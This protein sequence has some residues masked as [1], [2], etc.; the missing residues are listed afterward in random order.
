MLKVYSSTKLLLMIWIFFLSVN[1]VY[2]VKDDYFFKISW[3][4]Q[5]TKVSTPHQVEFDQVK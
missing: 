2:I 5:G 1:I 3:G 4:F